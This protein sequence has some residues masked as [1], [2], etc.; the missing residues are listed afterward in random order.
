MTN[1][2]FQNSLKRN[3]Q[4]TPPIWFMRQAGRYHSHYRKLKEKYS[5]EDLCKTV[6]EQLTGKV[7]KVK[8]S[9]R[10]VDSPCCLVTSEFGWSANMERIMKAQ[11]LGDDQNQSYMVSKKI[12]EINPHHKIIKELKTRISTDKNDKTIK[13]LV[14][15]LFDISVLRCGFTLDN[16]QNFSNRLYRIIELGLNLE[17]D[18]VE[19]TDNTQAET[20]IEEES[21]MEEV[22]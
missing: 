15:S 11:A 4:K 6:Q 1:I 5:F 2:L 8:I 21:V 12:M 19:E 14:M 7:E 13:D 10:I 17:D 3:I 20:I 18:I 16:T 22:D 9:T